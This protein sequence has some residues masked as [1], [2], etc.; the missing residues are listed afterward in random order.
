MSPHELLPLVALLLNVWLAGLSLLRN[1]AS[2]LHRAFAYLASGMALWNFGVFMLRRTPEETSAYLWEVVIHVGVIALPAFYYYFVLVFLDRSTQHRPSLVFA[3]AASIFFTAINLSGSPLLLQGVT[4]TFWGWTPE[5]GPLYIPFFLYFNAFLI[6]GLYHLLGAYK[7]IDSSFR[8]NR[9]LLILL[10]TA[11][12]LSGGLI[13]FTRFILARFIPAVEQV[14]PVGIPANMMFALMLGTSII[15]YRLF[16]VNVAVKKAWLYSVVCASVSAFLIVVTQATE[17]YLDWGEVNIVWIVVPLGLAITLLLGPVGW[18]LDDLVQRLM[19]SKRRG[20]YETLLELSKRMSTILEFDRVVE[21]LVQGLVR[22]IPLTHCVLMM[23]DRTTNAFVIHRE[24]TATGESAGARSI[25]GD[26]PIVRWLGR[27]GQVLVK[28]EARLNPELARHFG[29]AEGELEEVKA[30]LIVP[31]TVED[32]LVGLLLLGEKLSGGIFD[33]QELEVLTVVATQAAIALENAGLYGEVRSARDFLKSMAENSAD[34]IITSDIHGRMTYFSPGAKEIFGY[35]TEETVGRPVG[36]YYRGGLQEASA[37]MQRLGTEGRIRNYETAFLAKDGR[38]VEVN[39]SVSLLRD[40]NGTIVGT[41]GVIRD[42]TEHKRLLARTLEQARQIQQILETV[43]EGML[44]L[45]A[46]RRVV[47]ANPVAQECLSVLAG[48]GV[49]DTLAHLNRR[50]IGE[51]LEPRPDGMPQEVTVTGPP[52]RVFEVTTRA[53]EAGPQ[54]GGWVLVIRDVTQEREVEQRTQQQD[55]LAAVGQLAAGIAHDFNNILSVVIGFAELVEMEP[56]L[57]SPV[58]KRLDVI[59]QQGQTAAH[60]IRQVLD[61]S[62]RSIGERR[63]LDLQIF[64]KETIKWL[65]RTIPEHIVIALQAAPGEYLVNADPTQLQQILTNLAVNARDAT[66]QGGEL[67][68]ALTP[69]TVKAGERPPFPG[70]PPGPWIVLSAS[71]TGIGIPP[72]VLPR[73]FEPFFTTKEPGKGTGLGLA[74]VYGLVKQHD[75]FINVTSQVGQ[76]TSLTIY[77]PALAVEQGAPTE[78]PTEHIPHGRGETILLVEDETA[79][80]AMEQDRLGRLGYRVLTATNGR[81]GLAIYDQHRQEIA[82]VMT[83]LVM[84]GM[85]GAE[86][87]RTLSQRDPRVKVIVLTGYPLGEE[88]RELLAKG[89]VMWLQK[90]LQLATVA[91]AIRQVLTGSVGEFATRSL[92]GAREVSRR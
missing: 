36:D 9:T 29:T 17:Q 76:G 78:V 60:L 41:L 19:F 6:Y 84:P 55:R 89:T 56:G 53:M 51:L 8:R 20:C 75:G 11:V 88:S 15:R 80:L 21:T 48:V 23:R 28:E 18:R 58:R 92:A 85:G 5:P 12:S 26:S 14:Y 63:P 64:L 72:E 27:S 82:L 81:E 59:V 47:L 10:G 3:C 33:V 49:G 2:R 31:L 44:L 24:A 90:P 16:D 35:S 83:D 74:Q 34:A 77:L 45:D 25:R 79:V 68:F 50:P 71:D 54:V 40:A 30:A 87:V 91:R 67:T 22:G 57:S 73:I 38:W 86:L 7:G 32:K 37:V 69:L 61:F 66:P 43:P 62:R 52:A 1:P 65:K 70:M 13:D 42:L 4:H 39:A 46:H